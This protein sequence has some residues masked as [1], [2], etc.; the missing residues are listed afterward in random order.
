M[1]VQICSWILWLV[2]ISFHIF[3]ICIYQYSLMINLKLI[4]RLLWC[5]PNQQAVIVLAVNNRWIGFSIAPGFSEASLISKM[6]WCYPDEQD[7]MVL[8]WWAGCYGAILMSR[9]L[10]CYPD[11]QDVMVQSWWAGCYEW[12]EQWAEGRVMLTCSAGWCDP[13]LVSRL[14]WC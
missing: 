5:Y 10:W 4:S 7:V 14:L 11:K 8:S 1:E 2:F 13:S 12:C 6:L 3:M 9:M